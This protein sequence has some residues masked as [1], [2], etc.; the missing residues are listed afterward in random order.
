MFRMCFGR[1]TWRPSRGEA[2]PAPDKEAGRVGEADEIAQ[3]QYLLGLFNRR[4]AGNVENLN[5]FFSDVTGTDVSVGFVCA[6]GRPGCSEVIRIPIA[7]YERV[8]ESPHRFL[9]APGHA[10]EVDDVVFAGDGYEIV[11]MKPE[12]RD[13]VNPPTLDG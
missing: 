2:R 8:R 1:L 6:C 5:R 7:D 9:I 11:E 10:A 3:R 13:L 4:T 12:Y